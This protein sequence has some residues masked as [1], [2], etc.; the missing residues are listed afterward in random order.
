MKKIIISIIILILSIPII[1][2]CEDKGSYTEQLNRDKIEW[3]KKRVVL[4]ED[5]YLFRSMPP[6][7]KREYYELKKL[8]NQKLI[9]HEG[10]EGPFT[11]EK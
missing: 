11:E 7:V 3:I 8:V 10:S 4:I 2:L 1:G 9:D 6:N 5:R